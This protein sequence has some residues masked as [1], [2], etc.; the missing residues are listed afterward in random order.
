MQI[1]LLTSHKPQR[2]AGLV[3]SQVGQGY[4][5]AKR[6]AHK[7]FPCRKEKKKHNKIREKKE[8]NAQINKIIN[9]VVRGCLLD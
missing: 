9:Y 7:Y 4:G 6:D 1:P 2:L 5:A 3:V 8:K